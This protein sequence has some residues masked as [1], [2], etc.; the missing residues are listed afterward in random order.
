MM[1]RFEIVSG[2]KIFDLL[3]FLK[4]RP[5]GIAHHKIDQ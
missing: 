1:K 3:A 4:I 5:A 2:K